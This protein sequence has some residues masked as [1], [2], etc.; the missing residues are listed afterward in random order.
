MSRMFIYGESKEMINWTNGN[1][2]VTEHFTVNDCLMLHSWNRLA[3]ETDGAD[4]NKLE[5]LC[6]K[7]EEIRIILN[8][9]MNIHSMFRSK[10]YN[11]EQGILLPTG[12]D[13]H[14]RSEAADFDCNKNFTIQQ[15]KDILEPKL[16]SLEIR[17]EFGTTN[18][19]HLD[20]RSPGPSGWYFHI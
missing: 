16:E 19:V 18:W 7:L 15:I 3:T 11:I 2:K 13:V 4:F 1:E 5:I 20:L 8:C 12:N 10:E 17:M 6:N 9:P 14:A